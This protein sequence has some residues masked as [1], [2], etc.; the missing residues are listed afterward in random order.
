MSSREQVLDSR[1]RIPEHVTYRAFGA[2][3][4]LL[5]L[6]TGTYHGLNRTGAR[7]LELLRETDGDVRQS[8][9]RLAEEYNRD[10]DEVADDCAELCGELA[11]RGL[12]ELSPR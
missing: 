10:P 1:A 2:E 7:L 8:V 12:L 3:T 4:M 9:A 11:E 6:D 5:N